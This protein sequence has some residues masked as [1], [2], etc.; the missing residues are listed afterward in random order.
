MRYLPITLAVIASVL[1]SV[2]SHALDVDMDPVPR[3]PL[4]KDDTLVFLI[5]LSKTKAA[6]KGTVSFEK[7]PEGLEAS[8]GK[9]EFSLA[10]GGSQQLVFTIKCTAWGKEDTIRPVVSVQGDE[11]VNFPERLKTTIVRDQKKLDKKPIRPDGLLA[12]FSCGDASPKEYH[13]FDACAGNKRF[14]EEGIWYHPGG[15][16]GRAVFGMNAMPYPRH[17]W[18]K[19]AYETLNNIYYKRGT[20]C[21]WIRKSRRIEEIP[22]TPRFKG[23]P[24]TTWRIGPTAMR[25]HE[26]E[27]LVGHIWSPQAIYTR[28]YLKQRRPWKPFQPS[29]D[30][31]LSLRRYKAVKGL[32]DG[33]L[34][35]TYLAMRGKRYHVQA[36]YE[37]TEAWRHLALLWDVEQRRLEIYLDGEKTSG[38]VVL[39]GKPSTDE[40]WYAAPWHVATFCNAAMSICCVSAEGG[41]GATD[42][43]EYYVFNR[44][45]SA[46]EIRKNMAASMGK[47]VTP[48]IVPAGGKF[49]ESLK[50]EIRSLWSNPTHR[51]TT[52]GSEPTES[53][54]A[55]S[56]PI[57]LAGTATLKVKSFLKGFDP[58]DTA[59][60]KF[61]F[62]G[63]DR[64][65]PSIT[66]ISAINDAGSVLVGFDEPVEK[67]SAETAANYAI[68]GVQVKAAKLEPD[69]QTV[70]LALTRPLSAGAHKLSVKNVRDRS[71]A[72]NVMDEL[73][74]A[75]FE[76]KSLRG[77]IGYWSFD[78]LSGPAVKDLSPSRIDGLAWDDLHPGIRRVEGVKGKAVWLDGEDDLVDVTD[79][80]DARRL[81]VNPKSPHNTDA[82]TV[83]LCFKGDP[84]GVGY[85]K[86]IVAKTYAYE[87]WTTNGNLMHTKNIR[88]VDGKWHHLVVT[89]Q[90]G[91]K[92]FYLDG[93]P[94]HSQRTR[95][96]KHHR[97]G[98][99]LGVG[100]GGYGQPRF[101]K[102]A[103]DD[104]MIF[105]RVLSPDE[106]QALCKTGHLG[107]AQGPPH[108]QT[109]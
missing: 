78:V 108:G 19:F 55:A 68:G 65:K 45:L 59:T 40:V 100:G 73:K 30:S 32:T 12:Y 21:F 39:N 22:Y 83:A 33:F 8:Q 89:Y 7:L 27:G 50:I 13:H 77:L 36:P 87:I 96:L 51:Y 24:K 2:E 15:V 3:F 66:C 80:L 93:K 91:E 62:L 20:I 82:G 43:D 85:K 97:M 48:S 26:G 81:R 57:E 5:N 54:P 25:G 104:V 98:V 53:S 35:A 74:G 60:A 105:N 42:R 70:R 64:Q 9:R 49:S 47:V 88:I 90:G 72:G 86:H 56:G 16:Q 58:S 63:P 75:A 23:D 71:K 34:E 37:W 107:E 92:K 103:I 52:D 101:F 38:P 69:G 44:A 95:L 29:S 1:V 17:R 46:A 106:A 79:Y 18:S 41:R 6:C 109:Q 102:G 67:A 61:E 31:F 11:R 94:V 14:W 99:G 84:D 10:A 4:R 76:L 28:W